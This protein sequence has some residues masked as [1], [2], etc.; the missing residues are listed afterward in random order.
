MELGLIMRNSVIIASLL[1]SS[2]LVA[3]AMAQ[4]LAPDISASNITFTMEALYMS[5]SAATNMFLLHDDNLGTDV[6]SDGVATPFSMAPGGRFGMSADISGPWGVETDALFSGMFTRSGSYFDQSSDNL[7]LAYTGDVTTGYYDYDN[8]EDA[9]VLLFNEQSFLGSGEVNATYDLGGM[10]LLFGPRS[11]YYSSTFSSRVADDL[12]AYNLTS[13][14]NDYIDITSANLLVGGQ[15]GIEGMFKA[16]DTFSFGG[17]ATAGLYANFATLDR[18]YRADDAFSSPYSG[19]LNPAHQIGTAM[20]LAESLEL[21]PKVAVAITP[22]LDLTFGATAILLN[23]VD[24]ARNH[25]ATM[26]VQ[27]G[28]GAIASEAPAF[29]DGVNFGGVSIGL[30]GHF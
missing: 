9:Q 15:I 21:S 19:A 23:G 28:N 20:G 8:S 4:D 24:E 10:K 13:T 3:P 18:N 29:H 6:Y 25:W 12:S 11:I 7:Q 2:T 27:D 26:G 1:A 14:G 5:R 17:R 16:N 22:K 30:K